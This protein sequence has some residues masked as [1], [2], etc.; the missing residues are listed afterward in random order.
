MKTFVVAAVAMLGAT[1]AHAADIEAR[2]Y[3]KAPRVPAFNWTGFYVGI[4]VGYGFNDRVAAFA[5]NDVVTNSILFGGT[6]SAAP[7]SY[8]V[9]GIL[10]G[11]QLSYNWQVSPNLLIGVETDFQGSDIKGG[12]A[13]PFVLVGHPGQIAVQ[14]NVEWFGTLR[15]RA[16]WLASDKLLVFGTGGLAYG[17]VHENSTVSNTDGVGFTAVAA[18]SSVGARCVGPALAACFS[19]TTTKFRTGY[20]AGGGIEYAAW[21]NVSFKAEY[22]YVNLGSSGITS[23]AVPASAGAGPSSYNTHFSDLDFHVLRAGVNYHF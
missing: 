14:Q 15:A 22:L 9:K 4:N 6:V 21:R 11:G 19:G 5:N 3:V 8:D 12:A 18:D 17:S 20:T 13:T 2:S 23:I 7:V 16:A 10:G 1:G